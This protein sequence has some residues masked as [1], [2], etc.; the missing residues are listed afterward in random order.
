M[1]CSLGTGAFCFPELHAVKNC[2]VELLGRNSKSQ[3]D[4]SQKR[5]TSTESRMRPARCKR[6]ATFGDLSRALQTNKIDV[7]L[8]DCLVCF[9]AALICDDQYCEVALQHKLHSA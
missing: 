9:I 3:A 8:T 7:G 1:R 6:W 5:Y 2:A 4:Y